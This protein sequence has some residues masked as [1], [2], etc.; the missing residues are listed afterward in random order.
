MS[1]TEFIPAVDAIHLP[2]RI[3]SHIFFAPEE[4][5][6]V[7][8]LLDNDVDRLL[9]GALSLLRFSPDI[10][11]INLGCPARDIANRGA[12]SGLL[13][14]PDKIARIFSTLSAAIPIP[15]TAKIRLGWDQNNLNYIETARAIQENGG[16]LIA[17]HGRTQNQGYTGT[18]DWEAIARVK[19]NVSLPVIAN[20]DVR[21]VAD[22]TR[23]KQETLCDGVMIGRAAL[24]NPKLFSRLDVDEVPRSDW[25][26][27]IF[28]HLS[29]SL[30]FLGAEQGL[31]RFRKHILHYLSG[32]QIPT[33]LR[34]EMLTTLDIDRF[35]YIVRQILTSARC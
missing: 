10:I 5:P 31:I 23:I 3:R 2:P 28:D 30:S 7:F 6:V 17:V 20:G 22:I 1:Y 15:I 4:R 16:A 34:L 33:D 24:A 11:D 18:A 26:A 32:Y 35:T 19:Q 12:G 9:K 25:E 8:Q 21:T 27:M 29:R 14:T 13:R